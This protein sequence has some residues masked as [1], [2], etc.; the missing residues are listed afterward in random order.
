VQIRN[1]GNIGIQIKDIA[2]NGI[3]CDTSVENYVTSGAVPVG[4][5]LLGQSFGARIESP[6]TSGL[7]GGT[8]YGYGMVINSTGLGSPNGAQVNGSRNING[9]ARGI[10]FESGSDIQVSN[11]II[12]TNIVGLY[13][14]NSGVF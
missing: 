8:N 11:N 10:D 14:N 2:V 6:L 4:I 3:Y 13:I 7:L 12:Q 5:N 1:P 9:W